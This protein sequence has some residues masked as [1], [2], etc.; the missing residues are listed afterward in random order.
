MLQYH[1]YFGYFS[2]DH[3]YNYLLHNHYRNLVC[4]LEKFNK[5]DKKIQFTCEA[6]DNLVFGKQTN[7]LNSSIIGSN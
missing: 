5:I 7:Y 4:F 1:I 3:P 6:D 2:I